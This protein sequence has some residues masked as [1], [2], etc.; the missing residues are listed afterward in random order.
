[1]SFA[2]AHRTR[3]IGIRIALGATATDVRRWIGGQALML[4]GLGLIIGTAAAVGLTRFLRGMLFDV[5]PLDPSAFMFVGL[6]LAVTA[7][8][9]AWLPARRAARVDPAAILNSE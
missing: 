3:E 1:M 9:A 4:T 7:L 6:T 8:T 2:V 5:D